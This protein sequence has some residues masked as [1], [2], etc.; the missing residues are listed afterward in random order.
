MDDFFKKRL[1]DQTP[2]EDGWNIPSDD[3]WNNAKDHFPKKEKKKRWFWIPIFLGLFFSTT[4]GFYFG[5]NSLINSTISTDITQTDIQTT[6]VIENKKEISINEDIDTP[7]ENIKANSDK[8][9]NEVAQQPNIK[10]SKNI[11]NLK[12]EVIVSK[13]PEK[14]QIFQKPNE[15]PIVNLTV[16]QLT[17]I[18]K[19]NPTPQKE[20]VNQTLQQKTFSKVEIL[21]KKDN[22]EILVT[23]N[24]YPEN[25]ST[26][27][28][29]LNEAPTEA[30]IEEAV[31]V[32]K[33]IN[34]ERIALLTN[35]VNSSKIADNV[36]INDLSKKIIPK[37]K[38]I[39][40]PNQ[41]IGISHS[42][43]L[44][45][46]L[47]IIGGQDPE[48][49]EKMLVDLKAFNVNLHY[50]KWL[51]KK[52]SLS[53]G[54]YVSDFDL[55]MDVSFFTEATQE[56]I[57]QYIQRDANDKFEYRLVSSLPNQDNSKIKLL[58]GKEIMVGDSIN[59]Q[60]QIHQKGKSYQIPL[61]LNHHVYKNR[62]EWIF[63]VGL[64]IDFISIDINEFDIGLYKE[65]NLINE[66]LLPSTG[67]NFIIPYLYLKTSLRY[68]I[69]RRLNIGLSSNLN[70]PNIPLSNLETGLYYRF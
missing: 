5:R 17:Q 64:A 44:L 20:S 48:T 34:A 55:K 26:I 28:K 31:A 58:P 24:Q 18:Q 21:S 61:H 45:R 39:H 46:L 25:E 47:E 41:E 7:K 15:A 27:A 32:P 19:N 22:L 66:P 57:D 51:K 2:A 68:H 6:P 11:Q 49:G 62:F 12:K 69:N 33:F 16:E 29:D 52:W 4:V 8:S 67:K 3:L 30:I 37:A 56:D 42:E 65:G 35:F 14:K 63:G 54:F 53:T 23:E 50:T 40:D 59:I 43:N 60:A 36:S 70:F 13:I 38:R 9:S 1:D 10:A